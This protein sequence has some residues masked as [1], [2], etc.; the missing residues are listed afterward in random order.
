MCSKIERKPR[1][2]EKDCYRIQ[3]P[4][5]VGA[6]NGYIVAIEAQNFEKDCSK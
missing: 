1:M 6:T 4:N 2:L 3:Q 5:V